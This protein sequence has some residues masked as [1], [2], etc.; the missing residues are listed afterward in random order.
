M[1]RIHLS[2]I[3]LLIVLICSG[4]EGQN[5]KV[6]WGSFD[7]GFAIIKSST[8]SMKSIAGMGFIG[9][10]QQAQSGIESGFLVDT[11]FRGSV[12]AV[13]GSATIPSV[14][15]VSQNY[16]NPFNPS[17][18]IRYQLPNESEVILKVFNLLGQEVRTLVNTIQ[19]AGNQTARFDAS[20]LPSGVYFYRL[21]AGKFSDIKKMLLIK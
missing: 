1:C 18:V 16:P 10:T 9:L 13:K 3:S 14:F 19:K 12:V 5:S 6:S 20:N 17:T 2:Q 11:L 15:S 7:M 8:I 21:Q 4:A